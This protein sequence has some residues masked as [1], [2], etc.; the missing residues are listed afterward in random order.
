[1]GAEQYKE[2]HDQMLE[3]E[4]PESER[5]DWQTTKALCVGD[6]KKHKA[7][8]MGFE[9]YL[10]NR[11][12]YM[13]ADDTERHRLSFYIPKFHSM[14]TTD[15][16]ITLDMSIHRFLGTIIEIGLINFQVD[17]HDQYQV[18]R[19][20]RKKIIR[21]LTGERQRNVYMQMDKQT[22]S[23]G[24]CTGYRGGGNKHYSLSV[25]LWLYDAITEVAGNLNM[26]ITDVVYLSWCIG[27]SKTLPPHC[28]CGLLDKDTHEVK[29]KFIFEL[30]MYVTRIKEME[31]LFNDCD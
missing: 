20:H 15:M 17:Y 28:I 27:T 29:E 3:E 7:Y 31:S 21:R 23:I 11:R 6:V 30:K 24:S 19:A 1:M 26:S 14:L 4:I 8:D 10:K 5:F 9:D 22:I 18:T 2:H 12:A 13:D 16:A 25:P